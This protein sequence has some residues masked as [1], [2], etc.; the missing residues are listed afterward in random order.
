MAPLYGLAQP[1]PAVSFVPSAHLPLV[2][3]LSS[4]GI[5]FSL[6]LT[7]LYPYPV[8]T[9]GLPLPTP[10]GPLS[11]LLFD[12]LP[13]FPSQIPAPSILIPTL[14]SLAGARALIASLLKPI[15]NPFPALGI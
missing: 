15:P 13:L 7:F 9:C 2:K 4:P 10:S 6:P 12:L 11:L 1:L 3:S 8:S 14:S 5:T